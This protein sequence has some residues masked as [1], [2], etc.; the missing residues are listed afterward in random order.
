[1]K[2]LQTAVVLVWATSV[3]GCGVDLPNGDPEDDA[4]SD[5][6]YIEYEGR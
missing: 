4:M 5:G 3:V 2:I 1:M 6:N